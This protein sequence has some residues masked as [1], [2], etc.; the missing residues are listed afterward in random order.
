MNTSVLTPALQRGPAHAVLAGSRW[1]LRFRQVQRPVLKLFCLPYA[2]GGATVYRQWHQ[3]LESGIELYALQLP[4]RGSRLEEPPCLDLLYLAGQVAE[5]VLHES[6]SSRFALFGHSMGALLA[7]EVSRRLSERGQRQPECLFVSGRHAPHVDSGVP[8]CQR[9]CLSDA[10]FVDELRRL[11]GTPS[12]V[13]ANPELLGLLMP[14]LRG[15]FTLLENWRLR[16]SPPLDLPL[17]ALAGRL[18]PHVRVESV[19]KWSTWTRGRFEL[20]TYPGGHFFV[21]EDEP[22]VVRD[23]CQ[24]LTSLLCG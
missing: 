19:R 24:R 2:G 8:G 3:F 4:G 15:D 21:H 18:D 12:D 23:V 5:A 7:F 1:F 17:V 9:R 16:P 22:R 20:L 6:G 13:L 11:E 14:A 10:E